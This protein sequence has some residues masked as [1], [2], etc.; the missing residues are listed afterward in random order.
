MTDEETGFLNLTTKSDKR[1]SEHRTLLAAND[2]C[3][4]WGQPKVPPLRGNVESESGILATRN[5]RLLTAQW[6]LTG[7]VLLPQRT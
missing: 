7:G 4:R 6:K 5:N 3:R 1:T 2:H